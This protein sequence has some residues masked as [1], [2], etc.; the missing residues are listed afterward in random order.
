MIGIAVAGKRGVGGRAPNPTGMPADP[1]SSLAAR[2]NAALF[3]HLWNTCPEIVHGIG[4]H[5]LPPGCSFQRYPAYQT[6]SSE[7]HP[8][9]SSSVRGVP[10]SSYFKSIGPTEPEL[11]TNWTVRSG[12]LVTSPRIYSDWSTSIMEDT[13][14]EAMIASPPGRD[15]LVVQ[16]FAKPGGQWA[17]IYRDG[18]EYFIDLYTLG[19]PPMRYNVDSLIQALSRSKTELKDRLEAE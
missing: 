17:E 7:I 16:L 13:R 1:S 6:I 8:V 14:I 9:F 2:R 3:R 11:P 10:A 12:S 4:W 15:E 18:G 5:E 19:S